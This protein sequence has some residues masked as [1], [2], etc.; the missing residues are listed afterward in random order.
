L[1]AL[2]LSGNNLTGAIPQNIGRLKQLHSLDLS[3]NQLSGVINSNENGLSIFH[4]ALSC[5]A[6]MLHYFLVMA[7]TQ[8]KMPSSE[9]RR[10]KVHLEACLFPV[11]G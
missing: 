2:N 1:I 7:A 8:T 6:L 11:L 3:G 5:R 4:Q 9:M 10:I